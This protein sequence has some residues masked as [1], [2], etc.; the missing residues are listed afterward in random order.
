MKWCTSKNHL[1]SICVLFSSKMTSG[2]KSFISVSKWSE[3]MLKKKKKKIC[4]WGQKSTLFFLTPFGRIFFL[5]LSKNVILIFFVLFSGKQMFH[6]AFQVNVS[7]FKKWWDIYTGKQ[8]KYWVGKYFFCCVN[9]M[10]TF[11]AKNN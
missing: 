8:E 10:V 1:L 7:W 9:E 11:M 4:Q 6:F 3:S 5:V 2:I